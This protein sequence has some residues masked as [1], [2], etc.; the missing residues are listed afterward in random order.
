[1]LDFKTAALIAT[2]LTT[3]PLILIARTVYFA[4]MSKSRFASTECVIEVQSQPTNDDGEPIR[5]R[6]RYTYC[7]GNKTYAGRRYYFGSRNECDT[8]LIKLYPVGSRHVVFYDPKHPNRS[9]LKLGFHSRLWFWIAAAMILCPILWIALV[10][11]LVGEW[12]LDP[13]GESGLL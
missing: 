7:I 8:E 2:A 9:T 4:V 10:A 3:V 6:L 13:D 12:Q 1:M 11:G 5:L